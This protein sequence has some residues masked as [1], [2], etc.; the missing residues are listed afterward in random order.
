MSFVEECPLEDV[1][2][3][4]RQATTTKV[5][6]GVPIYVDPLGLKQTNSTMA[7]TVRNMELEGVPLKITLRLMLKQLGLAYC[8][9][10]GAIIISSPEIVFDELKEAQQEMDTRKEMEGEPGEGEAPSGD[11]EKP[12]G[13]GPQPPAAEPARA[14]PAAVEPVPR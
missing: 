10:D 1:L 6:T 8:V 12:A 7:S 9:H 11:D 3:Y 4:I 14:K 2:K 5:Y 13:P